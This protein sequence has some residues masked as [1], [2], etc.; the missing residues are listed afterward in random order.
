MRIIFAGTPDV[1]VPALDYL[2]ARHDIAAVLTRAPA[3]HGRKR[4]M[5]PSPVHR[6]ADEHGIDVYT[7]STLKDEAILDTLRALNVDAAVVVAYGLLVPETALE[8]PTRGWFNLHFSALPHWRGAAPVQYAIA[9]GEKNISTSVFKLTRGL[10]TGPIV[11]VRTYE[12]GEAVTSG[13][14]LSFLA[15]RGGKQLHDVLD[16]LA[17]GTATFTE[18]RGEA[19]FAPSLSTRDSRIDWNLPAQ[20]IANRIRAYTPE[21]SAWTIFNGQRIKIEPVGVVAAEHENSPEP[22]K[23]LAPG[24]ICYHDRHVWVGTGSLPVILSGVTPAGK[25]TMEAAAWVRGIHESSPHFESVHEYQE[26]TEE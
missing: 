21:P 7:P 2:S 13:E 4:I 25:R 23:K 12:L 8:I 26:K 24:E 16:M 6:W 10:D 3:P 15:Q 14:A 9:A 11:D 1:A 20:T 5:T 19:T 18:Q 22:V 17:D